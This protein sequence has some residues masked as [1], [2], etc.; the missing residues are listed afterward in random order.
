[1]NALHPFLENVRTEHARFKADLKSHL[2]MKEWALFFD[3]AR[4]QVSPF[5]KKEERILFT[6]VARKAGIRAGGPHCMLYFDLHLSERP[7]DRVA[8]ATNQKRFRATPENVSEHL[9]SIVAENS[10]LCIPLEDHF[11]MEAILEAIKSSSEKEYE[12]LAFTYFNILTLHFEK[13]DRCLLSMCQ[14]LLS[15]DE[16]DGLAIIHS[17]KNTP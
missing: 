12:F 14:T 16:L 11:A 10:P 13:E 15:N 9:R 1:M 4:T 8:Q 3:Y 17:L 7:L 6:A 2:D 5:E